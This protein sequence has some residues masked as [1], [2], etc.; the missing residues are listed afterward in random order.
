MVKKWMVCLW[1]LVFLAGCGRQETLE[2]VGDVWDVPAMAVPRSILVDLPEDAVAGVLE[3]DAGRIYMGDGYEIMLQTLEA[4]DLDRTIQELCGKKREE[5]TVLE[6]ENGAF[7]RYEFV[8]A[9]AGETGE[10]LGRSVILDDGNYHYCLSVLR[11]ADPDQTPHIV[12]SQV[13]QSFDL[14]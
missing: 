5:L 6:R 13:F 10:Q 12:W 9:A 8:W 4:G 7:K 11:C 3:G 14:E 1:I 2:T